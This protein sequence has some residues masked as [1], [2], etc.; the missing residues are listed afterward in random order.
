M[1]ARLLNKA[2]H[3][4]TMAY[5]RCGTEFVLVSNSLDTLDAETWASPGCT[6]LLG[7][8]ARELPLKA[9]LG[10]IRSNRAK[11]IPCSPRRKFR[12]TLFLP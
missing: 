10:R 3:Y 2:A 8:I 11:P 6:S 12:T 7:D 9:E 4:L 5:G 1:E